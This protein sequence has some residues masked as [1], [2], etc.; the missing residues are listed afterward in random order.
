[1]KLKQTAFIIAIFLLLMTPLAQA[2][3]TV[4]LEWEVP[5][6]TTVPDFDIALVLGRDRVLYPPENTTLR[7]KGHLV[8]VHEKANPT[9]K[10]CITL[11]EPDALEKYSI[12]IHHYAQDATSLRYLE[13]YEQ[14]KDG[15]TVLVGDYMDSFKNN[16]SGDPSATPRSSSKFWV[17]ISVPELTEKL[18]AAAMAKDDEETEPMEKPEETKPMAK[19]KT[20]SPDCKPGEGKDLTA[21]DFSGKSFPD[22][23]SFKRANISG[24]SFKEAKIKKG[25]FNDANCHKTDFS[26]SDLED[27]AFV[28]ADCS[29]ANFTKAYLVDVNFKDANLNKT[30]WRDADIRKVNFKRAKLRKANYK[31]AK[32]SD[33]ANFQDIKE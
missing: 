25:M 19:D 31:E 23:T 4:C 24:V 33:E 11:V 12:G 18:N 16:I 32:R 3:T 2:A 1:M 10:E 9:D 15:T 7:I 5:K 13:L 21:C 6:N 30:K 14:K 17:L 20:E 27:S 22:G 26:H 8:A 29:Q 28:R